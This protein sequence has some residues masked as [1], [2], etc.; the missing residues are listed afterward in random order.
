[1]VL[2]ALDAFGVEIVERAEDR[3]GRRGDDHHVDENAERVDADQIAVRHAVVMGWK[4]NRGQRDN[5]AGKP[6]PPEYALARRAD[7]RINEHDQDAEGAE[8]NLREEASDIRVLL[9]GEVYHCCPCFPASDAAGTA[10]F[11]A[12]RDTGACDPTQQMIAEREDAFRIVGGCVCSRMLSTEAS[13]RRVNS[14]EATPM[15]RMASAI[16]ARIT[17]SRVEASGSARFFSTVTSPSAT[18]W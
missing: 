15:K 18:R 4:I 12:V 1:V 3:K 8:H 11:A 16:V 17:R 13:I 7:K 5:R 6:E 9:V 2:A 14:G 10:E